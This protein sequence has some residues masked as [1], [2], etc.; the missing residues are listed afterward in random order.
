MMCMFMHLLNRSVGNWEEEKLSKLRE[1]QLNMVKS[2]NAFTNDEV[3]KTLA[4]LPT[5]DL[6]ITFLPSPPGV[7]DLVGTLHIKQMKDEAPATEATVVNQLKVQM[8]KELHCKA[9]NLKRKHDAVPLKTSK[10]E[11]DAGGDSILTKEE[12]SKPAKEK[13]SGGRSKKSE[14]EVGVNGP[15]K[16]C[17][18]NDED[19]KESVELK[20]DGTTKEAVRPV[21]AS[22]GSSCLARMS[23]DGL[24]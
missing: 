16:A 17:Q 22:E 4:V 24:W 6:F 20:E 11:Q 3:K 13:G 15:K 8:E 7:M 12:L 2:L 1:Q 21:W 18:K 5:E 19:A 9:K 10:Q 14:E 23:K